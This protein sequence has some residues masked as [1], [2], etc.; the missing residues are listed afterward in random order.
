[1]FDKCFCFAS[2]FNYDSV[3][4]ELS[5]LRD[6]CEMNPGATVLVEVEKTSQESVIDSIQARAEAIGSRTGT[7]ITV[8]LV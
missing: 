3:E 6:Y 7:D 2:D 5:S 1:M 8:N 4:R